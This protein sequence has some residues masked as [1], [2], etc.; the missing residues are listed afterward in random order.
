MEAAA[1][2]G[3]FVND[4]HRHPIPYHAFRVASRALRYHHFVQHDG[5]ISIAR[6][7]DARDW[8]GVLA[9]AG[10][11]PGAAQIDWRFPFRLCVTRVKS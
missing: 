1:T 3:W 2:I 9:D 4:L 5:P 8:R 6:A 11:A 7:F 10:L